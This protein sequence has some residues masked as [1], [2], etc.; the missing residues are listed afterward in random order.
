MA[1]SI[2]S[3]YHSQHLSPRDP[4]KNLEWRALWRR[5]AITD[6]SLQKDFRQAAFE[7]VL[8][9]FNAFCWCFEPRAAVKIRPFCTWPH[10]NPA[11]L[12][13]DKAIDDSER[14]EE[15]IDVVLDK[16]RGQ[17]A[18]WIYLMIFLRRWLRDDLFSAGLV[19]RTESLVDS[20]R[21]PDTLMWK[22]CWMLNM[23]PPWM[24]PEG[25]NWREH[26]NLTEH[27]LSNPVNGSTIVGYS[28]TG[29]VARGGRKSVFAMDEL[30]AFRKGD[31]YAAMNS[32]QHVTNCRFLVSTFLGDSGAYYDAAT[33]DGDAVKVVLDWKENPTQNKNLYRIVGGNIRPEKGTAPAFDR[34]L[35][36]YIRKQHNKLQKRGYKLG[37][38]PRSPWYNNQCLRP[39]A[40]PRGLAQELA[41]DPR[42]SVSKLFDNEILRSAESHTR[43]PEHRGRMVYDREAAVMRDPYCVDSEEGDLKLWFPIDLNGDPPQ[44]SYVLGADISAG[45]AGEYSSNSVVCVTN[46]M[47]GEQVAEFASNSVIPGQFAYVCVALARWFHN[48]ELIP[49]VN[50]AGNFTQVVVNELMYENIFHRRTEAV[51]SE[52]VTK[53]PGFWMTNDD[54]KLSLFENLQAGMG[55]GGFVPRSEMMIKECDEYEYK[56]GKII[57]VGSTKT[58]DEGG[59]GKAHGD[60]VLA[61]SLSWY[62]CSNV[63]SWADEEEDVEFAPDG[64]MAARLSVLDDELAISADP[65]EHTSLD[66]FQGLHTK[67]DEWR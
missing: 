63:T 41:R 26:R 43:P 37:E 40:T 6:R 55:D 3:P 61:A 13:M 25:F 20:A 28:A 58:Q 5:D 10:Q 44:G 23:L 33:Q 15:P 2:K 50:F 29:D 18:T 42:G 34:S 47:T 21:D 24:M 1:R 57:H 14:A 56:N 46:K 8:F 27:S 67:Y 36:D 66:V 45:T 32:T 48:G 7:D 38:A 30:A 11:I 65:W 49:E 39:G 31:D 51:G 60:R 53:K 19:T 9:W 4:L 59:K 64:S 16:S 54:I 17:G 62:R 35:Q 22:A 52:E 12:A